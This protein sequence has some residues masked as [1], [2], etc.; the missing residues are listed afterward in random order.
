M[1]PD[2]ARTEA[3]RRALLYVFQLSDERMHS[4]AEHRFIKALEQDGYTVTTTDHPDVRAGLALLREHG[5][6]RA[7]GQWHVAGCSNDGWPEDEPCTSFCADRRAALS[8]TS[9]D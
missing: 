8:A 1:T 3:I 4:L 9:E 5:D 2:E 7:D 6:I